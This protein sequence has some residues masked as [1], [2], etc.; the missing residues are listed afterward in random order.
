MKSILVTGG[1]GFIGS[2]TALELLNAGYK[3]VVIDN[4]SNSKLTAISRVESLSSKKID[5]YQMDLLNKKDL[6]EV[7][8]AYSFDAVIHF[9]A[10]KAVGESVEEPLR[11]YRNNISGTIN[12]CEI[13]Q[14]AGVNNFVFSSSA[15]VYGDP[16]QSPLTEDSEL[17]AVNP[18]GQTKLTTEYLL[19][20]LQTANPDWNVALLRYFNPVGAHE[21]GEIGEDPSGIPNNLMPYVTQV[22]VGKREKLSVF[23]NDY[24]TRDGTGERDYIHVV[25]LA[26]GHLKALKKLEENPGLVVYNLGTGSGYTVLELVKTF[27]KI[28][29]VSV[30]YEIAPR[31]PGDAASC[32]ADPSKAEKELGWTTE[33][34]LEEMC[35]DA[36]NWQQKNPNGY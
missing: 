26:I 20:D 32:F 30:P 19:K 34:G 23:G 31:R 28:N 29:E 35:R 9:A 6:R 11:Y 10:L 24:P 7:F 17:S 8:N 5:F 16:S 14:E 18:Y 12:L 15:T 2:H 36:W 25:D 22:A 1:A 13:M 3:V 4:L 21:S 33:R 27:E